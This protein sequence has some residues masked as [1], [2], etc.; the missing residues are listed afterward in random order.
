METID[1][2]PPQPKVSNYKMRLLFFATLLFF[3]VI[4][5][6]MGYILGQ[7]AGQNKT[8]CNQQTLLPVAPTPAP[9][10]FKF[11]ETSAVIRGTF[12]SHAPTGTFHDI[13]LNASAY[14][15][16]PSATPIELNSVDVDKIT[17]NSINLHAE[18]DGDGYKIENPIQDHIYHFSYSHLDPKF[19]FIIGASACIGLNCALVHIDQCSGS[20][21]NN[22]CTITGSGSIALSVDTDSKPM[23][24][25]AS[26]SI[27]PSNP[28]PTGLN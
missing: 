21:E 17:P 1:Q 8:A 27:F 12:V 3:V 13:W 2:S 26:L 7:R 4:S 23:S 15:Y 11:S 25:Q 20:L 22:V 6:S 10:N 24:P 5:G 19:K 9:T 28:T 14:L 16:E 18:G